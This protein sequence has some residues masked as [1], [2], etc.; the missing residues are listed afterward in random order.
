M[1][2]SAPRTPTAAPMK[3][4]WVRKQTGMARLPCRKERSPPQTRQGRA[5]LRG[6]PIR[7]NQ[8]KYGGASGIPEE[9]VLTLGVWAPSRF[10]PW[11][12]RM[13]GDVSSAQ[14]NV[15]ELQAWL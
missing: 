12:L 5:G 8:W 7:P 10:L 2:A 11:V 15:G 3:A 9:P 6:L 4:R 1:A 14:T 13:I